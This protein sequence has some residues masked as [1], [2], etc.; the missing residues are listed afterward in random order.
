MKSKYI[1]RGGSYPGAGRKPI[2]VTK[3]VKIS[4]GIEPGLLTKLDALV[5]QGEGTRNDIVNRLLTNY[6]EQKMDTNWIKVGLKFL[7][8]VVVEVIETEKKVRVETEDGFI[9]VKQFWGFHELQEL[10]E[11]GHC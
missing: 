3:R 8:K 1:G 10:R 9:P 7:G 6:T 4:F 11:N 2:G 5:A